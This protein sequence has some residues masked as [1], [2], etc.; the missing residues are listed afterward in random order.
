MHALGCNCDPFQLLPIG[1]GADYSI[2]SFA[3]SF[4]QPTMSTPTWKAQEEQIISDA[5]QPQWKQDKGGENVW[6][7]T[8]R[9]D[10]NFSY[11]EAVNSHKRVADQVNTNVMKHG[12]SVP[13]ENVV[14]SILLQ[15]QQGLVLWMAL[16]VKSSLTLQST[17]MT[18]PNKSSNLFP[19]ILG[20]SMHSGRTFNF[21]MCGLGTWWYLCPEPGLWVQRWRDRKSTL[22]PSLHQSPI[23]SIPCRE[24]TTGLWPTD[25]GF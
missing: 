14:N 11:K 4:Q 25:L 20:N 7:N 6:I 8:I 12:K 24:M 17:W 19:L 22:S 3:R 16:E 10:T 23:S 9:T 21:L 15:I 13:K 2:V 5:G 1:T 18:I